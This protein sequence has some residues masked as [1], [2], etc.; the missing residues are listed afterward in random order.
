MLSVEVW[1]RADTPR[2]R[3]DRRQRQTRRPH[4]ESRTSR[5]RSSFS[6]LDSRTTMML[7]REGKM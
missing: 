3:I 5:L 2:L 7:N 4:D 6:L 1:R